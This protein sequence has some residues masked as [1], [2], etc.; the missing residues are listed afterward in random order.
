MPGAG[1]DK[2]ACEIA[3]FKILRARARA[4]VRGE[5]PLGLAGCAR[6]GDALRLSGVGGWVSRCIADSDVSFTIVFLGSGLQV[7]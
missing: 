6:Q 3:Y 2:R 4:D 7:V 1:K 5:V